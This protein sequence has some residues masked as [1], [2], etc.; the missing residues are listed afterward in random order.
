[1]GR[2]FVEACRTKSLR[3]DLP[4]GTMAAR[5]LG[6]TAS[7]TASPIRILGYG[8]ADDHIEWDG[9][10]LFVAALHAEANAIRRSIRISGDAN[11]S[12]ATLFSRRDLRLSYARG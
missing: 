8:H 2:G 6:S 4:P 3:K 7:T 9:N 1:M 5:S 10:G 12:R 11:V